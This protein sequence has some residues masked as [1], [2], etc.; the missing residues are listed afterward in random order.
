MTFRSQKLLAAALLCALSTTAAAVD[1]A[2]HYE[3]EAALAA[4]FTA[5]ADHSRSAL[6]WCSPA[7]TIGVS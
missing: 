3:F 4:P 1:Y 5:R 6:T 7:P 2:D